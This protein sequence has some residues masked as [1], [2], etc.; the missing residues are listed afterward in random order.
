MLSSVDAAKLKSIE[1]RKIKSLLADGVPV[2]D[3]NRDVWVLTKHDENNAIAA[4]EKDLFITRISEASTAGYITDTKGITDAGFTLLHEQIKG[5]EK[6]EIIQ[7]SII[8]EFPAHEAFFQTELLGTKKF[9]LKQGRSWEFEK[10][11]AVLNLEINSKK[12]EPGLTEEE[13]K[14]LLKEFSND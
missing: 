1:P 10:A 13:R 12:R 7:E 11:Q 9:S 2:E 4:G 3:W 5:S 6:S 14:S 8:G